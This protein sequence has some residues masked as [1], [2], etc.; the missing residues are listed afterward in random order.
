MRITEEL[1]RD[2]VRTGAVLARLF[3]EVSDRHPLLALRAIR[4][5]VK[6]AHDT[7][8]TSAIHSLQ[9]MRVL[10]QLASV[11]EKVYGSLWP[12]RGALLADSID[13]VDP[14]LRKTVE[15]LR[16]ETAEARW[17]RNLQ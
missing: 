2:P 6:R 7:G 15:A 9:S 17:W 10:A 16:H 5:V 11:L 13:V 3:N 8:M 1:L 12:R 4:R 14:D